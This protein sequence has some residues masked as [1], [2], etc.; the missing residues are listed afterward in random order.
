MDQR[1]FTFRFAAAAVLLSLALQPPPSR[2]ESY[3]ASATATAASADYNDACRQARERA[4]EK[5]VEEAGINVMTSYEQRQ[6]VV[7]SSVEE[8]SEHFSRQSSRGVASLVGDSEVEVRLDSETRQVICT[9]EATFAVDTSKLEL[10]IIAWV[11]EQEARALREQQER[12]RLEKQAELGRQAR[13][14]QSSIEATHIFTGAYTVWCNLESTTLRQCRE[15]IH[16]QVIADHH[17]ALAITHEKLMATD[18]QSHVQSFQGGDGPDLQQGTFTME[19]D[20]RIQTRLTRNPYTLELQGLQPSLE[21]QRPQSTY[22]TASPA[23]DAE[24]N[25]WDYRKFTGRSPWKNRRESEIELSAGRMD[26][27]MKARIHGQEDVQYDLESAEMYILRVIRDDLIGFELLYVPTIKSSSE[28]E[29]RIRNNFFG[30]GL[31]VRG[32]IPSTVLSVQGGA[33]YGGSGVEKSSNALYWRYGLVLDLSK[34]I[35]VAYEG[36]R[37]NEGFSRI[38]NYRVRDYDRAATGNSNRYRKI[39]NTMHVLSFGVRF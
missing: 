27:S 3:R 2:A 28:K 6:R 31:I 36:I 4:R 10:E 19:G 23:S 33:G 17:K 30:Y 8:Y 5:V 11:A 38:S 39:E 7:G 25:W 29:Y 20:F 9:V 12:A 1:K 15:N 37:F 13:I 32:R 21:P 35:F 18:M 14:L 26:W 22:A 24:S 34:N 16:G